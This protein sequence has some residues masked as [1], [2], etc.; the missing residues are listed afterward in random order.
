MLEKIRKLP[1]FSSLSAAFGV[2]AGVSAAVGSDAL[3]GPLFAGALMSP[4]VSGGLMI[5]STL[6][7]LSKERSKLS[8]V[9]STA[10]IGAAG[11][12]LVAFGV[13]VD[14]PGGEALVGFLYSGIGVAVAGAFNLAAHCTRNKELSV[15]AKVEMTDKN[16]VPSVSPKP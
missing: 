2:V 1:V 16:D 3:I 7:I 12:G 11:L 8:K 13:G 5:G 15:S 9:F 14:Q 4:V 6:D 10:A